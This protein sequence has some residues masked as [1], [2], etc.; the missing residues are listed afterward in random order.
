MTLQRKKSRDRVFRITLSGLLPALMLVMGYIENLLPSVGVPGIKLGLS[1]GVLIFALYMLDIP[2]AFILMA[3]KV[4]LSGLLF[5]GV[6]A[7]LY[8]F[9]G[10]LTSLTLMSLLS[11]FR[12]LSLLAVSAAGGIAHNVGQVAMAILVAHLPMQIFYYLALL[13][14][15]GAACGLLTGVCAVAVMRHLEKGGFRIPQAENKRT[16]WGLIV[17]AVCL[18]A[19][20]GIWAFSALPKP[21]GELKEPSPSSGI[22]MLT[23]DEMLQLR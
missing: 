12:R 6:S 4:G 8:A 1:N 11:R 14:G 17:A 9:A 3:V 23:T 5:S 16:G 7:M 15:A 20:L 13:A 21:A 10:G 19:A 18:T 2:T 22:H